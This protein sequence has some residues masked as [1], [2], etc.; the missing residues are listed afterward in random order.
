MPEQITMQEEVHEK[1]EGDQK[2]TFAE[3]VPIGESGRVYDKQFASLPDGKGGSKGW[4]L[5]DSQTG[6]VLSTN[7]VIGLDNVDGMSD[8]QRKRSLLAPVPCPTCG[9][10]YLNAL[11]LEDHCQQVHQAAYDALKHVKLEAEEATVQAQLDNGIAAASKSV[12]SE[13][14]RKPGR[15]R[16]TDVSR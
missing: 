7:P 2:V 16:L 13:E 1:V 4:Y 10:M 8:E 9:T 3:K 15:P 11:L 5:V 12:T 6:E 14:K